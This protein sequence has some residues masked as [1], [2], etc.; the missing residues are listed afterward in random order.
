[1]LKKSA[2]E[3]TEQTNLVERSLRSIWHPCMVNRHGSLPPLPIERG[4]GPWLFDTQ[5]S[6]YF[7]AISSWWV[8]LFGHADPFV[9]NAIKHQLDVLPHVMLSGCT[10]ESAVQLGERLS[11]LTGGSLGHAFYGSDG[12]SAV[13]IALK[14]SF[15]YWRALG[16]YHKNEFVCI[17]NGYHG[18]TLGALSVTDVAVFRDSYD[19]LLMNAHV[20]SSP[21]SRGARC[22]ESASA[23]AQ[24]SLEDMKHLLEIRKDSIS[25]V[26]VEP[27]I[28]CAGNMGMHDASYLSGLRLLCNTFQVHLIADEIA[29]GCGRTGTFFAFEQGLKSNISDCAADAWPDFIT[30]SKGITAGTLPLSIV[31]SRD[32]VFETLNSENSLQLSRVR[33]GEMR[34][35]HSHSYSGNPLACRAACAVLERFEEEHVLQQNAEAT[36]SLGIAWSQLKNDPRLKNVRQRGMVWAFDVVPEIAGENFSERFQF[37]ARKHGLLIR[38]IGETVYLMPPYLLAEK[39]YLWLFDRVLDVLDEVLSDT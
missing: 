11:A 7:D 39:E 21:D 32:A 33:G 12:S 10:H 31:L 14:M 27:L 15:Y 3:C 36:K 22:G 35:L 37:V 23:V 5:G 29:V 20:V 1:M 16:Y 30:L 28:Q 24:R 8:N 26:I 34:F 18:E 13:E 17:K 2:Q 38:P 6:R 4:Q 9:N 25:A 19:V